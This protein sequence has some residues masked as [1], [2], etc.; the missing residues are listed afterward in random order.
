MPLTAF[1]VLVVSLLIGFAAGALF[2][3]VSA[4]TIF[5]LADLT[6]VPADLGLLT[7]YAVGALGCAGLVAAGLITIVALLVSGLRGRTLA[8]EAFTRRLATLAFGTM[9]LVVASIAHIVAGRPTIIVSG[10]VLLPILAGVLLLGV[11]TYLAGRGRPSGPALRPAT[12]LAIALVSF[13][14]PP[15][16]GLIRPMLVGDAGLA[17]TTAVARVASAPSKPRILLL[18]WDGAT[19]DVMDPL[20]R[21]GKMPTLKRLLDGGTR[22]TIIAET[23]AIQPFANSASA[24]ARTPALWESIATGKR[25]LH[26]G[27]WDFECNLFSGVEQ[28]IPFRV[29]GKRL[30]VTVPTT[31]DM[32]RAERLWYMLDRG[33]ISSAVVGWPNTWPA[34]RGLDHGIISSTM[35]HQKV[36]DNVAPAGAIDGT[37]L[38]A[39]TDEE[40]MQVVRT[41]FNFPGTADSPT[42][43]DAAPTPLE[44]DLLRTFYL[45]Y[46]D[47]LCQMQIALEIART[48]RP[49]FLAVYLSLTDIVQHKFWRY[50]QPEVF[51]DVPPADVARYGK[52]IPMAYEFFDGELAKLLA[53][54]GE[55]TTV[56]ILSDHGG[57]PWV[58]DGLQGFVQTAFKQV[59]PEYSGN[60]R[61]NG[62]IA[63]RG[64]GIAAGA[65]LDH[66]KHIDIVPT[67]LELFGLPV[68]ADMPGRVLREMLAGPRAT[69]PATS[70]PTYQVEAS[71]GGL[72]PTPNPFDKD[73]EDRLR[74]LGYVQ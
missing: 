64:P 18:G 30:G 56:I 32:G 15:V 66:P 72:R 53:A 54:V 45:D 4:C 59:H 36:V 49:E 44:S 51:G 19:W 13:V 74:A 43:W 3:A 7:L 14:V 16:V 61:L 31:G 41:A 26:H 11:A 23:E 65:A 28:A 58:F 33:G 63:A 62:M 57:G 20:L 52:T 27:I 48:Q 5:L 29:A 6:R 47:D 39:N 37:A 69:A 17:R 12:A 35:A 9:V 67:V 55:D 73:I 71:L 60:H 24:G 38:C 2:G 42:P 34:R 70:I 8:G 10:R 21:D 68:G 50:Y 25:P 22:G 40:A 1:R 46:A